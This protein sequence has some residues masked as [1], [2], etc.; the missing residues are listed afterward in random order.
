MVQNYLACDFYFQKTT[1][2]EQWHVQFGPNGNKDGRDDFFRSF[3]TLCH[4]VSQD[5]S[6]PTNSTHKK[7]ILLDRK[8][9]PS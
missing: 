4:V 7:S 8:N 2:P 6:A 5:T 1:A 3:L 9:F